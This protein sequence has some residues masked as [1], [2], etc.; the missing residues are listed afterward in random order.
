LAADS[1]ALLALTNGFY[2]DVFLLDQNACSS[3]HL[4]LWQGTA[5]EVKTAQERFWSAIQALLKSKQELPAIHAVNKYTH[6]CRTAILIKGAKLMPIEDS[7]VFRAVLDTLPENVEEYQGRHGFFIETIDNDLKQL[8]TIV[9]KRYQT[10]T[11]FGVDPNSLAQKVVSEG[12]AGIDRIV[13]VGKALDI[14]VIWDG[15]DLIHTMSRI[16]ATQ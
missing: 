7:R 13:P 15:Y 10:L 11:C 14:S 8:R 5:Q 3:P 12:L 16:V 2:N 6:L 4:I 1:R 9:N